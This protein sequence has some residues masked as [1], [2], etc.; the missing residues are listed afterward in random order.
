[1]QMSAEVNNVAVSEIERLK[2][3]LLEQKAE[4]SVLKGKV[5]Q[6]QNGKDS[7]TTVIRILIEESNKSEEELSLPA[8]SACKSASSSL[9]QNMTMAP[10]RKSKRKRKRKRINPKTAQSPRK[11]ISQKKTKISILGDSMIKDLIGSKMSSSRSVSVKSFSGAK[12]AI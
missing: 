2:E 11:R 8:K 4:N 7:L 1:M 6:L 9:R 10:S 5:A 12:R 3:L